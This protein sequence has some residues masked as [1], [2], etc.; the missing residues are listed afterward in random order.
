MA[1]T[2]I[3]FDAAVSYVAGTSS[4]P[5]SN[6]TKLEFYGLYKQATEVGGWANQKG[7]LLT[8]RNTRRFL[9][10]SRFDT[11]TSTHLSSP[12]PLPVCVVNQG[13]CKGSAPSAFR[14]VAR[15]KW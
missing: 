12:T 3:A 6:D 5:M 11:P 7:G 9:C 2:S 13:R 10:S 15:A 8:C 1:S 4:L 14:A